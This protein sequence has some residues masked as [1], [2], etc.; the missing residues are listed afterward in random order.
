MTRRAA[1]RR[2]TCLLAAI[3]AVGPP[4]PAFAYLKYG[5]Q[6]DGR[7]VD[8]GWGRMPIRY[9][10]TERGG[11]GV[12]AEELA[13]AVTRAFQTWGAVGSATVTSAFQGFTIAP[14]GAADGRSTFG[15]LDRPDLDRVLGELED[16][17]FMPR[18][19]PDLAL[20]PGQI[21]EAGRS[22][23]LRLEPFGHGNP[24]PLLAIE[25]RRLIDP[26]FRD[27]R[28]MMAT[29]ELSDG[30]QLPAVAFNLDPHP[31]LIGGLDR[32][33]WVAARLSSFRDRVQ[34]QI[35]DWWFGG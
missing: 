24:E 33:H 7:A 22:D 4:A 3:L 29:V 12:T 30:R 1:T 2:L 21:D 6:V 5:V 34:L 27:P 9:F 28:M 14:P 23:L 10:V 35:Q 31:D 26:R 16:E 32:P 18:L 17:L 15:F 11:P 8:V 13:A 25:I 19:A 20:A